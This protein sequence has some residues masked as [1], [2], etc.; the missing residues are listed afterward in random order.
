V[1]TDLVVR[2]I[3]NGRR[4][5]RLLDAMARKGIHNKDARDLIW[6]AINTHQ[7][8]LNIR[9]ELVPGPAPEDKK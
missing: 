9:N 1:S 2:L 7:I 5:P 3:G 4:V 6:R 8:H